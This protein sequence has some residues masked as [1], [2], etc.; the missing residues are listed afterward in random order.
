MGY[1]NDD[2][3]ESYENI[4]DARDHCA[5][6]AKQ[7]S[8]VPHEQSDQEP[9]EA[10]DDQQCE[11][12]IVKCFHDWIEKTRYPTFCISIPRK[13]AK[14]YTVSMDKKMI[15]AMG[16]IFMGAFILG[17]VFVGQKND[18]PVWSKKPI[19]EEQRNTLL[20]K[21]T[22]DGSNRLYRID[23]EYP[24][25]DRASM[26]FNRSIE[27]YVTT[28]LVEFKTAAEENWKA[29]QD[30]MPTGQPKAEYPEMPFTFSAAWMPKQINERY[31]SIIVRIDSYEGGAHGR[32]E[33]RTFNYDVAQ[34]RAV[35][36]ADLFPEGSNYLGKVSKYARERL[37]E[38][39]MVASEG[40]LEETMLMEGTA[41][42]KD[43]FKNFTFD[44]NVIDLYFPKYQVAPGAFGEQHV[45]IWRE[46]MK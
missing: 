16:G 12:D 6:S 1:G 13:D 14:G 38:E 10:A 20:V 11:C 45:I 17:I 44:D 19:V 31:I 23:I 46:N 29:R 37:T 8:D 39:L 25:F 18:A 34:G 22:H 36:L 5:L 40:R 21:A 41:P 2:G 9:V 32:Q 42:T 4:D 30:T 35:V 3:G 27:E 28:S 33:L 26:E 7:H 43:N 24:Q 15:I